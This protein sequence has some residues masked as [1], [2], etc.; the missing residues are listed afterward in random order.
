MKKA[1]LTITLIPTL[2][3]ATDNTLNNV[4]NNNGSVGNVTIN[5][6][7]VVTNDQVE[8]QAKIED[9]IL[10]ALRENSNQKG[11]VAEMANEVNKLSATNSQKNRF[12]KSKAKVGAEVLGYKVDFAFGMCDKFFT[13]SQ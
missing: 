11:T 4:L 5:Q 6:S 13:I 1:L 12:C 7:N 3:L 2:S 9:A 8:S 10:E